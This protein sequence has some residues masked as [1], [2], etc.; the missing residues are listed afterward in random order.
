MPN[1]PLCGSAMA[2]ESRAG[3]AVATCPACQA[4]W[5]GAAELE[6]LRATVTRQFVPADLDQLR[7]SCLDRQQERAARFGQPQPGPM[8]PFCPECSEPMQ[9]KAFT[10][11]SGI[12]ICI[13]PSHGV[14]FPENGFDPAVDFV[15]RGGEVLALE[16]RVRELAES[17]GQLRNRLE[18]SERADLPAGI[19]SLAPLTI[20]PMH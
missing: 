13:C 6:R 2:S 16:K 4:T 11:V 1:C 9:R 10:E 19:D 18:R 8:Y 7:E 12:I 5:I 17:T 3:F 15:V 20:W 14:L